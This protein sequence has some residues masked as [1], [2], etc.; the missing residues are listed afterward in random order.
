MKVG[1]SSDALV[2]PFHLPGACLIKQSYVAPTECHDAMIGAFCKVTVG[3]K[4][5]G[6][7]RKIK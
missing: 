3:G 7:K 6:G 1:D 5:M 4:G 2:N